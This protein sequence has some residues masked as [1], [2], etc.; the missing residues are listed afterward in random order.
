MAP[1][2]SKTVTVP[3]RSPAERSRSFPSPFPSPL[4]L[5]L[6][7]VNPAL[8]ASPSS[9]VPELPPHAVDI[10]QPRHH[11]PGVRLVDLREHVPRLPGDDGAAD[12]NL[13]EGAER[14]G[15]HRALAAGVR[16]AR[17]ERRRAV[18]VR[19]RGEQVERV[20][21][22]PAQER[23]GEPEARAHLPLGAIGPSPLP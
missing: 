16:T 1:G 6:R 8:L 22:E 13:E 15:G 12:A 21:W 11:V 5:L 3:M 7:P 9:S 2:A 14:A 20:S 10:D 23:R 17:H 19:P 18:V 4:A